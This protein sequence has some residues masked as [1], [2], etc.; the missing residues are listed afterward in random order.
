[1]C[2]VSACNG[3]NTSC[4][5]SGLPISSPPHRRNMILRILEIWNDMYK[6]SQIFHIFFRTEG[7]LIFSGVANLSRLLFFSQIM[8]SNVSYNSLAWIVK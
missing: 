2:V 4:N 7:V 3:C 8:L 5:M 6:F 1:M